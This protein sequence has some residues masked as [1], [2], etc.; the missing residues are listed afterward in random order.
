MTD[1]L[2]K[3]V[4]G[5]LDGDPTRHQI[6]P[7][8]KDPVVGETADEAWEKFQRTGL[9]NPFHAI[10]MQKRQ[11]ADREGNSESLMGTL[12]RWDEEQEFD[13]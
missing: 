11:N 12:E 4:D 5:V 7:D 2:H 9:V 13:R 1:E 10:E 6:D 8:E 3:L